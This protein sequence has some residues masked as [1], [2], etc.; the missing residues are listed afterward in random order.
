M[1]TASILAAALACAAR[2]WRVHPTVP[3]TKA[4]R[5]RW[6]LGEADPA[7]LPAPSPAM[8]EDTWWRTWG[9][10]PSSSDPDVI[11]AW[12]AG[13]PDS[14][15]GVQTGRGSDLAIL[16]VDRDDDV[17]GE[18]T[19]ARLELELGPLPATAE[20]TTPRGGRQLL[21]A[22]PRAWRG[23]V[24]RAGIGGQTPKE[25]TGLDVRGDGG[26]A[27]LA[28]TVRGAGAY[29]WVPGR[30]PDEHPLAEL[31]EGW[32]SLL[33]PA[34]P[35]ATAPGPRPDVRAGDGTHPWCARMLEDISA[36][37][38]TM[39][40][41]SGRNARL[42][43]A[44]RRLH[45]FER[46]IAPGTIVPTLLDA[47]RANGLLEDDGER[48]VTKTIDSGARAGRANPQDPPE[49]E[50]RAARPEAPPPPSDGDAPAWNE[51][52]DMMDDEKSPEGQARGTDG[53]TPSVARGAAEGNDPDALIRELEAAL[54]R[55]KRAVKTKTAPVI[56]PD[57]DVTDIV[58]MQSDPPTYRLTTGE[59]VLTL[60]STELFSACR[61]KRRFAEQLRRLPRVPV[62]ADQWDAI[63]N[64]W[65]TG[66]SVEELSP[67]A[68]RDG[69]VEALVRDVLRG[70]PQG[71]AESETDLRRGCWVEH[72]GAPPLALLILLPLL[73]KVHSRDGTVTST[74]V[75][76]AL[77]GIGWT[78]KVIRFQGA[79]STT[80]CWA[81]KSSSY[82]RVRNATCFETDG[83]SP[84]KQRNDETD[85]LY[86]AGTGVDP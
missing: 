53:D 70:L 6:R 66:A 16:D 11:R 8:S 33:E 65:L 23:I 42:F 55:A 20:Q 50:R 40:P 57:F 74:E 41:G 12:W 75:A 25:R 60:A 85:V 2:G 59:G 36:E 52:E 3:G 31:P 58:I 10:L 17:D 61:F 62:K 19:L 21:F 47:A 72:E 86:D 76:R 39:P 54:R 13:R 79:Q 32:R 30:S 63:V 77:R 64:G 51:E 78:S 14:G 22:W 73:S 82:A 56:A 67:E 46:W 37:L 15:L 48:Q 28:P 26:Q 27:L 5:V 29:A 44:S 68:S 34:A 83:P 38:A 35:K 69:Y 84:V 81:A 43:W 4:V 71:E 18:A 49:R 9:D 7:T 45:E 1:S 80:R 24:T